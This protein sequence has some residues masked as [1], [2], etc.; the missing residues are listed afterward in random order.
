VTSDI[1]MVAVSEDAEKVRKVLEDALGYVSWNV[2]LLGPMTYKLLNPKDRTGVDMYVDGIK[3]GGR[4]V[5]DLRK[6]LIESGELLMEHAM[7]GKLIRSK[8]IGKTDG[9]D[10]AVALPHADLDILSDILQEAVQRE[11]EFLDL[12]YRNLDQTLRYA[13]KDMP[14]TY[15]LVA[16]LVRELKRKFEEKIPV[17]SSRERLAVT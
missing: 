16:K 7:V 1:D 6:P 4:I 12:V 10:I 17:R 14:E 8:F 13:K 11:P 5:W 2:E 9:Y 3:K 15:D